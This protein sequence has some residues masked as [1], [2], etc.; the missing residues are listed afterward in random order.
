MEIIKIRIWIE[1]LCDLVLV[2]NIFTSWLCSVTLDQLH[3]VYNNYLTCL[4]NNVMC[5]RCS[6]DDLLIAFRVGMNSFCNLNNSY[7]Y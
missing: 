3:Y 7:Q 1:F 2:S 4:I 5:T 6:L